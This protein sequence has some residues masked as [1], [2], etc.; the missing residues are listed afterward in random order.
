MYTVLNQSALF[1]L[2]AS[3]EIF[4]CKFNCS[5]KSPIFNRVLQHSWD[6][7]S[8]QAGFSYICDIS[9]C[10]KQFTNLQSYRR[11]VKSKHVWFFERYMKYFRAVLTTNEKQQ[12]CQGTISD[13]ELSVDGQV[14]EPDKTAMPNYKSTKESD[15]DSFNFEQAIAEILLELREN[16]KTSTAATCFVSE[17]IKY[18]LD[19]DRQIH[20]KLL[21]KSLRKDIEDAAPPSDIVFSYKTNAIISSQSPFSKACSKFTGEKSLSEYVKRC[22][23]FVEPMQKADTIQ[24]IPLYKTLN[25]LLSHEDALSEGLKS[26]EVTEHDNVLRTYHDGSAF[27]SN[28]L[29]NSEKKTLEIVLY[30]DDFGIVNPLGNK[31]VKYKTSG[32]YFVLGNLPPQYRSRQKDIHLAI[33]RSSKLI[34]K[35]GYQEILRPFIDD[36][37][38]LETE[39]IY[40]KFDNFVHQ[41]YGTLTM[42]VANNLAAHA[43]GG[44]SAISILCNAFVVFVTAAK[45]I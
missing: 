18:I 28:S 15:F 21:I 7:H 33:T 29:L 11:H 43:L 31:T 24:Y 2:M 12:G 44:F 34:S 32:F 20:M 27:K 17:K 9:S 45:K 30:H 40:I 26:Q 3:V 42:V 1:V 14:E 13:I 10:C 16:F 5:F 36:L 38:K 19:I 39:G 23:S 6:K 35:Y 37:R 25:V 8:L 41:F 4:P 22:D